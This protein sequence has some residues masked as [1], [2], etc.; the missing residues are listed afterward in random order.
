MALASDMN[1]LVMV[2]ELTSIS[3][4]YG[5]LKH[6]VQ[7]DRQ[8]NCQLLVN[9]TLEPTEAE[10]IKSKFTALSERFLSSRPGYLGSL[11]EDDAFR[12]SV[13]A[14]KTLAEVAPEAAVLGELSSIAQVIVNQA[15]GPLRGQPESIKKQ[16]NVLTATADTR[17]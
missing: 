1:L 3:D 4:A 13:A 11:S 6:L 8:V 17:E 2:P 12:Q 5:L 7:A 9:R 10:Y 15:A 14:Q 16:T